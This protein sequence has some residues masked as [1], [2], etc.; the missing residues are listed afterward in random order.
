MTV[1][2]FSEGIVVI[3]TGVLLMLSG[4]AYGRLSK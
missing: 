3:V 4:Y 2:P 1:I